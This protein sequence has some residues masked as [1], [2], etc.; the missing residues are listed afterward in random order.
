MLVLQYDNKFDNRK[1][2]KLLT[3]REVALWVVKWHENGSYK[4][5]DVS[6]KIH[7]TKVNGWRLKPYLLWF[8]ARA[9][10]GSNNNSDNDD[11]GG[12]FPSKQYWE[13]CLLARGT[14][15]RTI[16]WPSTFFEICCS[17][18]ESYVHRHLFFV[19][20]LPGKYGKCSPCH[21]SL[22]CT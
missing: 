1:D 2:K 19:L 12:F 17:S 16:G 21:L 9:S 11:E 5:Q 10:T 4:L 8:E 7:E 20:I 22:I 18:W 3:R 14:R 15:G 6:G 13:W